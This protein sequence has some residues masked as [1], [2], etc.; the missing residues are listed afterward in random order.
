M[1]GRW[2]V[3]KGEQDPATVARLLGLLPTW[4]GIEASNV[5]Y[6]EAARRLPTYLARPAGPTGAGAGEP[7]GVLLADRH[8]PQSAEIHL[9]AVDPRLHRAG[10]GRA[11]VGAL[12]ADLV[13]DGCELLQVKTLG[14]SHPDAG[15]A[16]TRKFY[17]SMGFAPV[18]ELIDFWGPQNPCL[19]MVK[20]LAQS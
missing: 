7:V 4:F 12:E 20:A 6:I 17:L 5:A 14:P 3:T 19:I 10:A 1:T 13:A 18:E 8:F 2:D 11:L 9:L 15:Y 16:L